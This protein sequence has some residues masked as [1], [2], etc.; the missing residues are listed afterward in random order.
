MRSAIT[1]ED[2]LT[3]AELAALLKVS[4][5]KAG[6]LRIANSWP[7]VRLGRSDIRYTDVQVQQIVTMMTVRVDRTAAAPLIE[8]QTKLSAARSA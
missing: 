2:L 1:A 5:R 7:H 6:E 8:G 4:K 3:E